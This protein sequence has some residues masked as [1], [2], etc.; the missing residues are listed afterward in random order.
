MKNFR[1]SLK[2]ENSKLKIRKF[3]ESISKIC[4]FDFILPRKYDLR[5]GLETTKII[6]DHTPYMDWI[7][8]FSISKDGELILPKSNIFTPTLI[9]TQSRTKYITSENVVVFVTN[10]IQQQCNKKNASNKV[11]VEMKMTPLNKILSCHKSGKSQDDEVE[12]I[13]NFFGD[14]VER[15][16]YFADVFGDDTCF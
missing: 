2:L 4:I 6:T 9:R 1:I 14:F 12:Q 11:E 16:F 15:S 8:A 5:I 10:V 13:M 7:N 3:S